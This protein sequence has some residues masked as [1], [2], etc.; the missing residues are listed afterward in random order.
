MGMMN[1]VF[2]YSLRV[3]IEEVLFRFVLWLAY[4]VLPNIAKLPRF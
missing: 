4:T 3:F 1:D 2:S